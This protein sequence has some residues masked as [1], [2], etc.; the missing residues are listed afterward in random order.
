MSH[1]LRRHCGRL[2]FEQM[3][4]KRDRI[5]TEANPKRKRPAQRE[6][7]LLVFHINDSTDDQVLFQAACKK[8]GV[9]LEWQVADSSARAKEFFESMLSLSRTQAVQWPDLVVLD[10]VMPGGS[11]FQ[12]LEYI[13]N[14]P[15]LSAL[16]VI[17]LT[18]IASIERMEK[19]YGLGANSFHEKPVSFADMVTLVGTIYTMWSSARRPV[20]R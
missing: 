14:K 4:A 18:G 20:I 19:A 8:A 16:P 10:L 11:G 17:I 1:H 15:E 6:Q 2:Y 5:R 13:R 7:R 3:G 9:P 12:V